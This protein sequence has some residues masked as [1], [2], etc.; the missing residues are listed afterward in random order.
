MGAPIS[1]NLTNTI[2]VLSAETGIIIKNFAQSASAE[3]V[4]VYDASQGFDVGF[5]S[6]NDRSTIT[7]SGIVAGSTGIYAAAPG[8][9]LTAANL[10]THGGVASGGLYT[11]TVGLTHA[12][13]ALKEISVTAIR[14]EGIA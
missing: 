5:V 6:H 9:A 3:R 1:V 4:D 8:V 11:E 10:L 7:M 12:E 2:F 14:R 13:K